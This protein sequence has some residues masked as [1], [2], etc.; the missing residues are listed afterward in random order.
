MA[1][2]DSEFETPGDEFIIAA[3]GP[4]SSLAIA[5]LFWLAAQASA[6]AGLH[7]AV[8]GVA[9]YLALINLVLAIFN[10]FPG[11][12]L[13][14]GRLFRALVWRQ[15]G[16][17]RR[18]TR[19]AANG[20]KVFGYLLMLLGFLNLFGGNPLGGLWLI[21]IGWFVRVAAESSY[22]QH[23]LRKSLEGARARDAMTPAPQTV[24]AGQGLQQFLDEFVLEG[25]HHSYPVVEDGHAVGLITLDRVRAV[26]RQEWSTRTVEDAMVPLA[27]GVAVAPGASMADTLEALR[28]SKAGRVLV[29]DEGRLVGIISQTDVARWID[30]AQLRDELSGRT[31]SNPRGR[32]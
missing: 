24:A 3:A 25:R 23:V 30:R 10:L 29:I 15:T 27:D 7:I 12:P 21:F 18:A 28:D 13:D 31:T 20:G 19:I 26:P 2:T 4:V 22:T 17:L 5:A 32:R 1:R 14:G 16:D 9:S 6:A 11:F 8:T